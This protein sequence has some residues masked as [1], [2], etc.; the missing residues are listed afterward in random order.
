VNLAP[1]VDNPLAKALARGAQR[2]TGALQLAREWHE[3]APV[4]PSPFH[5]VCR[6][7]SSRLR[8]YL[9]RA[10]RAYRTP[11]LLVTSLINR[12]YI[13]DLTDGNSV[14]QG[15][16]DRGWPV[17]LV[18]WGD[19]GEEESG[20]GLEGWILDRLRPFLA[21]TCADAGADDAHLLGQC[22]GGTM[23]TALAAVDDTQIASLVNLT[24]PISFVDG[25][26]FSK[27]ARAPLFDVEAF[28]DRVGDVPAWLSQPLFVVA[29]PLAHPT[30]LMRLW[31]GLGNERF[32][33][34]F[35]C[36]E[37]WVNDNLAIPRGFFVDLIGQLYREDALCSG[38]LTLGGTPVV[39]EEIEAPTL[40]VAASDDHIVPAP[41]ALVG[42]D[43]FSS[44]D[45][46]TLVIDGGHIGV[47]IG[48][49]GRRQFLEQTHAWMAERAQPHV[50]D[51]FDAAPMEIQ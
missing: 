31:Q 51:G 42:A 35:R 18:D 22:L 36:M 2:V 41:S 17:Y 10:P 25:G 8:R 43:R 13:L 4:A 39:L 9:P 27:W 46:R 12:P 15:L 44:A 5:E 26:M 7:G 29:K 24:A 49:R 48:S 34:L 50:A 3:P 32:H 37:T 45:L 6:I 28:A 19:P 21:A 1:D 14:V 47:V 38:T 11:V 16:L 40:L 30:K 23:T 33:H 20:L